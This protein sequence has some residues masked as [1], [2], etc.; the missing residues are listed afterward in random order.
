MYR[1][2]YHGGRWTLESQLKGDEDWTR[3][4]PLTPAD[5]RMLREVLWR[6]YQRKRCPWG[7]IERID[8]LLDGAAEGPGAEGKG[9]ADD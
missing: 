5:W 1:A 4:D 9:D 7:L 6:K 8:R 3:H 2:A